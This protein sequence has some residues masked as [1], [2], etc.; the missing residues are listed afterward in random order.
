[1]NLN[2]IRRSGAFL[3]SLLLILSLAVV[4]AAADDPAPAPTPTPTPDPT[5]AVA[6]LS[7]SPTEKTMAVNDTAKLTVTVSPDNAT[8]KL[9]WS[10]E[11]PTSSGVVE[12]APNANG[13][14]CTVTAKKPGSAT[15]KVVSEKGKEA[16]CTV[17][18]SGVVLDETSLTMLVGEMKS[19]AAQTY[20]KAANSSTG[21]VWSST[22][23]SVA[24]VIDGRIT[25]HYPGVATITASAG[26]YSASAPSR[27]RKMWRTPSTSPQARGRRCR[28]PDCEATFKTARAI[29]SV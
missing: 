23:I 26:S 1:M 10:V 8:E 21:V 7:F 4:P 22:N 28:S 18:V 3:L 9:T 12:L 29:S 13:R 19:L 16:T 17:T 15:I 2:T 25:G 27:C 20:G 6:N 24:E 11:D 14:E 5:V